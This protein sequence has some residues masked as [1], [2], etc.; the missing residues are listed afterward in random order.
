VLFTAEVEAY[1]A[2]EK[3]Y[4]CKGSNGFMIAFEITSKDMAASGKPMGGGGY[5]T[6]RT[7]MGC[8]RLAALEPSVVGARGGDPRGP[9]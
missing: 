1:R 4:E 3:P 2:G 9:P 6:R 8:G 7:A 5:G